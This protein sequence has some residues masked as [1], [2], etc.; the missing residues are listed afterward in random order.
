MNNKFC[1]FLLGVA[2]LALFG[3]GLARAEDQLDAETK[4]RID[5]MRKA[6]RPLMS[7]NIRRAS[8]TTTKSSARN[9]RN[10]TS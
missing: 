10:A 2:A 3:A 1:V 4:A 5:I 6:R 8:R 7:P 9:A